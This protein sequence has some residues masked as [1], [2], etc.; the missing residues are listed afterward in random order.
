M[1]KMSLL[2]LVAALALGVAACDDAGDEAASPSPEQSTTAPAG[3]GSGQGGGQGGG[4]Q[5]Q[6]PEP[7]LEGVP[8]TVAVVNG[9]E[10]SREEFA[11]TFQAQLQQAAM[12]AQMSGQQVDQEQIKQQTVESMVGTEL[13]TQEADSR[14]YEVTQQ[15]IDGALDEVM[16]SSG[17]GSRDELMSAMQ[18]QGMDREEVM[19]Q[20]ETQVEIDKLV[21]EEGGDTSPSEQ[22]LR[23]LYEQMSAQGQAGGQGGQ[24]GQQV[25][26]FEEMRPQLEQQVRSQ[27]E[28]Q[29]MQTLVSE[30]RQ[31]ADVTVNL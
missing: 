1:R 25:P 30:L 18:Q 21:A 4:Q 26:S 9:E 7:D 10:I 28:G 12:Q 31:D 24:G 8:A 17:L 6:M 27:K 11:S 13:L 15:D 2:G 19:D 3:P 22:E 20:L 14:D 5:P 16:Q 29:A 23:Q